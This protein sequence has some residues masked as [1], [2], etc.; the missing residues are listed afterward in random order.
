MSIRKLARLE[1]ETI[2]EQSIKIQ[3]DF[4]NRDSVPEG[5]DP[6]DC[7]VINPITV[8]TW[9]RIRP[10]LWEIDKEDINKLIVKEGGIGG[11]FPEVMSKYGELLIDIVCIGIHNKPSQKQEMIDLSVE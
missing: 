6:G 11:D 9:F 4:N 2:T 10:L 1:S 3:F 7:I 8:R 5:K